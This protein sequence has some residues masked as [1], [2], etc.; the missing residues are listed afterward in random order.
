MSM[1]LI[2]RSKFRREIKERREAMDRGGTVRL[3][4]G[5]IEEIERMMVE[6]IDKLLWSGSRRTWTALD[7]RRF[8]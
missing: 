8:F 4:P 5:F 1:G 7:A 3:E 2:N 6:R